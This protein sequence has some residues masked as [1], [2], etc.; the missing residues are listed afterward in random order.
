MHHH[1]P[2]FHGHPQS[3]HHP[4]HGSQYRWSPAWRFGYGPGY[5]YRHYAPAFP[6]ASPYPYRY[7]YPYRYPYPYSYPYPFSYPFYGSYSG[8][9]MSSFGSYLGGPHSSDGGSAYGDENAGEPPATRAADGSWFYCRALREY[10]P[11]V[12]HCPEPWLEV[13]PTPQNR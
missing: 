13:P 9:Y 6:Y 8:S 2:P 10:Y 4:W 1:P 7:S 3:F 12:K 11:D 5:P